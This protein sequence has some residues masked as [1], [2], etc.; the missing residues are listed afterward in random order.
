MLKMFGRKKVESTKAVELNVNPDLENERKKCTFKPLE[1]TYFLDG[2]ADKYKERRDREDFF[3]LDPEL[4]DKIPTELLSHE[5]QYHECLRKAHVVIKKR[6]IGIGLGVAMFKDGNPVALHHGMFIPAILGQATPEQQ[7]VWLPRALG[8]KILGTYAQFELN[9]PSLSAYKWWP[10]GL[11]HT[12]NYAVIVAQLYSK[13]QRHGIYPFI[14]QLRDEKTHKPMPGI[15][16][17]EIGR[18][19]GMNATNNGFLAFNKVRIPRNQMLMKNAQ[20]LPDGTFVKPAAGRGKLV[21]GAMTHVRVTIVEDMSFFVA[22]AATIAIRYSAVRRQSEMKPGE[23][24]PQILDYQTQQYKLLPYLAYSYAFRFSAKWLTDLNRNVN[25]NIEKG[26]VAQLPELHAMACC[27]KAVCSADA[28]HAVETVRLACGGHGY[29]TCS[30][31]PT[32][33]GL[34][35]AASTY[36]GENTVLLLQTARALMKAWNNMKAGDGTF[37]KPAAG[38]GKLVYGAMTHVRVTIVEDMSFFVAKAATIAIRYSAV[39]RQSEM[40][41]GEME[42]Q[43]LDYQT[44]QYKLL[45]YLAYSYAFRFSAKWLTDLNR[46]VNANIEKGDVAQLPEL[47]AMACCLKAVCSADAAH[48]VE[49][50]RLACGGHGYM[51]CSNLPTTYGLV[52]AASTYEGENTVLLLQTA[53]ALM[54]AWNNMKAGQR[55]TPIMA[56]LKYEGVPTWTNSLESIVQGFKLIAAA[57]VARCSEL[58]QQGT[59]SGLAPEMAWN[60][61]SVQLVEAAEAHCRAFLVERYVEALH[62]RMSELSSE[63]R[64][65]MQQLCELYCHTGLHASNV[66][67]LED[68]QS[69]LLAQLRPNAVGLVDAFDFRDDILGSTLG[70]WDG[71]VYQRLL[72]S[73]MKS[74]LNAKPV[75]DSFHASIAPMLKAKY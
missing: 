2:G 56:Y 25:A 34:V 28:A 47:H 39:R 17:G 59:N 70:A 1:L 68:W 66:A 15:T 16:I 36:E 67:A 14:V 44:Q 22:K 6:R 49:T 11:G 21:Y 33:Y 46:N 10:G 41:P 48:A 60:S 35:T 9:T 30:N 24:E 4:Q 65:V 73:A 18:K 69:R 8:M 43:I 5:D 13:G 54:K 19:L 53:R 75:H 32:T 45:P 58:L 3:L 52:T 42:P 71:Q 26:D 61:A 40:K 27:L 51:T 74:P 50:V 37:V 29:M 20:V 72:D 31:L 12:A 64:A 62:T 7:E 55:M 57:K 38:R 23:M 63:L